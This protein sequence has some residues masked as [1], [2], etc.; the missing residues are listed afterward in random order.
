[1]KRIA[2]VSRMHLEKHEKIFHSI[3]KYLKREKKEVFLEGRVASLMKLKKYNEF[4]P[5]KTEVDLILV[6]GGD[7]TILR[8]VNQMKDMSTKFFGI[9]MGHLGFLS[10][11]PP[12]QIGKTLG[13]VFGGH[14]TVDKRMMI[15]IDLERNKKKIEKFHALNEVSITQGTLSRLIALKAR[16]D[17]K[18]LAN[19]KSDGL[20]ISTP[21]GSTAYSLSAGG[22]I[23][24]PNV[25]AMI[26]TP[27]CPHSFTHKPIVLPDDKK[28]DI[29]VASDYSQ[30]NLTID[31]QQ[32]MQLKHKD[33]IHIKRDGIA[34]FIRLPNENYFQT[35][36]NK[37]GWG[38][39]IEKVL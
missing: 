36:R 19:Y 11:I 39:K 13:R 34:E 14:Y 15:R 37:L 6:M 10:E 22:P 2:I 31:G 25:K 24:H 12:V 32:S 26:I 20:I 1:M 27:I 16:V 28:V 17:G 33:V 9:N 4:I 8:I 21:T 5:G 29:T 23:L 35:L 30:M 18:K 38:S 3:V 7:G